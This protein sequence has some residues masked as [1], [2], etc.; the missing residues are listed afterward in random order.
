MGS[1]AGGVDTAVT[2]AL[3]Q[4]TMTTYTSLASAIK[5]AVFADFIRVDHLERYKLDLAEM[6]SSITNFSDEIISL[7][8]S[9]VD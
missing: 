3:N 4:A 8:P 1:F 9:D 7:S 6:K 5:A 2:H